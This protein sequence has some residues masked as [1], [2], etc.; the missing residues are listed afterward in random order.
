[1]G[2]TF[3][4]LVLN[5]TLSA[6]RGEADSLAGAEGVAAFSNET[7]T[8][9]TI[10]GYGKVRSEKVNNREFLVAPLTLIVPGVLNGS[11]GPLYYPPDQI[12]RNVD[13]WN[14]LPLVVLHPTRNGQHVSGRDPFAMANAEV[15]RVY[16]ARIGKGGRL[17][18]EGWF[19]VEAT[20]RVDHT[21]TI[22]PRRTCRSRACSTAGGSPTWPRTTGRTTSP[23]C[24]TAGAPAA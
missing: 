7:A 20:E 1:M 3:S 21:K 22:V 12:S 16:N 11:Q 4:N 6:P 24:P 17:Q 5:F 19:D 23:S 10:N 18:A 15:G 14:G 9:I 8:E 13:A 2:A